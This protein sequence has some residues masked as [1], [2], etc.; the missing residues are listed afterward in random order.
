MEWI[1]CL[2]NTYTHKSDARGVLVVY[3]TLQEGVLSTPE[4]VGHG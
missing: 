1:K 3:I 2:W 4:E